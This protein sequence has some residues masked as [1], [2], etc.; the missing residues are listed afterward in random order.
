[1]NVEKLIEKLEREQ[2]ETSD[3]KHSALDLARRTGWNQ[4]AKALIADLRT[5]AGLVELVENAPV[6]TRLKD[7][8][9]R[10]DLGGEG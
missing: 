7:A 2:Y 1:M 3:P 4:R 10:F 5:E 8:M 6:D 9:C